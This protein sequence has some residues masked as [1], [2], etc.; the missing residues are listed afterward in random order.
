[1]SPEEFI[2][3]EFFMRAS[4]PKPKIKDI[5][6]KAL[7]QKHTVTDDMAIVCAGLSKLLV[8]ELMTVSM[9]VM[10]EQSITSGIK[11]CHVEEAYRR[12]QRDGKVGLVSD[13]SYMFSSASMINGCSE[14]MTFD[15]EIGEEEEQEEGQEEQ[16]EKQEE[17]MQEQEEEQE[18]EQEQEQEKEQE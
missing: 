7:G 15:E 17:Q 6:S 8:G 18:K 10:R 2:R 16:A 14:F 13:R 3:F 5:L 4:L 9:D 11:P 12:M 1:M